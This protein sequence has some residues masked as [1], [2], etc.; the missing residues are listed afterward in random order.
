MFRVNG[1]ARRATQ[2]FDYVQG[3]DSA[4]T[5]VMDRV[6]ELIGVMP[7]P[8]PAEIHRRLLRHRQTGYAAH[9][10]AVRYTAVVLPP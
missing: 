5:H 8:I 7:L 2:A 10:I 3:L 6:G 4:A 9:L 1:L